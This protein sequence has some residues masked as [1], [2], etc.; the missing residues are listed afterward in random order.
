[1]GDV[2]PLGALVRGER[3]RLD[4]IFA[5]YDEP[6]APAVP[7]AAPRRRGMRL[8]VR[9]FVAL[10]VLLAVTITAT[11]ATL[12]WNSAVVLRDEAEASAVHLAELLAAGF[13]DI[14]EISL[15]N[16][17]RTLD[18]TLDD[19]MIAQ[20]RLAAHLVAAAEA[21]GRGP[22]AVVRTL[23]AV[24]AATVVDEF[25]ITDETAFSYLTNVRGPD[26]VLV[27]FRFD[28]DPAVQP[29]ASKFYV[30]L[31]SPV[32]D[33]SGVVT[34]PA[35]VREIDQQVFKYVGVGGVDRPR[36]VQVG[37][38]LE[39][40]EQ[41]ILTNVYAGRRAD[42]SAVVEGIVGQQMAVHATL[43]GRFVDAAAAAGWSRGEIERRLRRVVGASVIGEIRLLGPGGDVVYAS[44]SDAAASPVPYASELAGPAGGG[45]EPWTREFPAGPRASDGA[46]WKY[47]AV[48]G[49]GWPGV[50]H[51]GV[52]I[53]GSAGNLLYAVYQREADLL[54]GSRQLDALWV[55]NLDGDVAAA[56]PRAAVVGA[57]RA[58]R[59][60]GRLRRLAE[61]AMRGGVVA[62]VRLNLF[63]GPDRGLWVAAPVVN[64]G[65]I[66]IGGLVLAV[67]LDGIVRAVWGEVAVTVLV[68]L[69]LL[70]LAAAVAL[71]GTWLWGGQLP[72]FRSVLCTAAGQ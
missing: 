39:F 54:V 47:V 61:R 3:P 6:A 59:F 23:E 43:A 44:L 70:V 13:A 12:V 37:N 20:A 21:A 45:G 56:A 49:A 26:G 48:A 53:D 60:S 38:R 67:G 72:A 63:G 1:M 19:Q 32:A 40:G 65:G 18:A 31:D 24:A 34:Q 29:Q 25:W 52:P 11:S 42:V 30:L 51:V 71:W 2:A 4:R 55:V 16:V 62:D 8:A 33:D 64:A 50:A 68:G 14:G 5:L 15:A 10:A 69:L 35:Q 7:A 22:A 27:P 46:V 41:E 57:G 9:G 28:P 17:A 66:E 58:P 36:I